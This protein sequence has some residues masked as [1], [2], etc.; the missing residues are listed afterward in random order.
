MSQGSLRQ[1]IL[2]GGAYLTVRQALGTVINIGGVLLL[3][4]AIGP[5]EYGLYAAA[6]GVFTAMQLAAQLGVGI[7]LVRHPEEPDQR[8]YDQAFTILFTLGVVGAVLGALAAPLVE[9]WTRLEGITPLVVAVFVGLPIAN[10]ALVPLSRLERSLEYRPIAWVELVAQSLFFVV[11]VPL[12]LAGWGAWAP[13]LGWWVQ[14]SVNCVAY[15]RIAHYRPRWRVDRAII[16]D[17]LR[18]GV[19]YSASLWLWHLRRLVNPFVVGRYLG[20]EA[21]AYVALTVQIVTHLNFVANATW[22]LSTSALARIQDDSAR[23][24]RAISE[25]MPLQ[26]LAVA[27]FLVL[28]GFVAPFAVPALLGEEW[29]ALAAIYPFI[30]VAYL[31]IAVFNL[32]CSALFALGRNREIAVYHIAHSGLLALG[33]FLLLPRFGLLGYGL[34]E[35]ANLASFTVLH[36]IT[37]REIGSPDYSRVAPLWLAAALLLFHAH[38]GWLSLVGAGIAILWSQPW[39][40]VR[41]LL[42]G[43]RGAYAR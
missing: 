26:A 31:T 33:A 14:H 23:L 8:V 13:L 43:L 35:V 39:R 24:V 36:M 32:H 20:A 16:R 9:S 40:A 38:L 6:V 3:T 7:Y 34:A 1:R 18:Y 42:D 22:R 17:M 37:T 27:P 11:S 19:D 10:I 29:G 21:V 5:A 41:G 25:G 2:R 30:A 4:R 15:H 28:F 12:A